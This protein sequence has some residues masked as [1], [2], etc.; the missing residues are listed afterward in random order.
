MKKNNL[1]QCTFCESLID[2][3]QYKS[4]KY[5][6]YC[7]RIEVSEFKKVKHLLNKED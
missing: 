5:C 7:H 1:Y 4:I 3:E 6:P 2:E